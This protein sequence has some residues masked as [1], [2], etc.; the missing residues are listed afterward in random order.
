[1]AIPEWHRGEEAATL[2]RRYDGGGNLHDADNPLMTVNTCD[3]IDHRRDRG[4][5]VG[6]RLIRIAA[7]TESR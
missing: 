1:V 4:N 2:H 6:E 7:F 3:D 5:R